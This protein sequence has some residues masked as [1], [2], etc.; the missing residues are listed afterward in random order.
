MTNKVHKPILGRAPGV[1]EARNALLSGQVPLRLQNVRPH[2][3]DAKNGNGPPLGWY[4][5]TCSQAA[6]ILWGKSKPRNT[7]N[8]RNFPIPNLDHLL[9][10]RRDVFSLFRGCFF[11]CGSAAPSPLCPL[12]D[13]VSGRR[14]QGLR[15]CLARLTPKPRTVL[16]GCVGRAHESRPTGTREITSRPVGTA[17]HFSRENS[18]TRSNAS[19]AEQV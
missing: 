18:G 10:P 8:T 13:E 11:A 17:P 7:L 6:K 9:P 4:I 2:A 14:E 12:R 15:P 19:L 16:S 3:K 5:P 1:L